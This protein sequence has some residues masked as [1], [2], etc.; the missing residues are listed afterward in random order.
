MKFLII[1]HVCHKMDRMYFGGYGPYV[2]EMNL[3]LK[4]VDNVRVIAP[5]KC[6]TFNP[7]DVAYEHANLGFVPVPSFDLTSFLSA[8]RAVIVMPIIV[9][10]MLLGMLWA[11]HIHLRCPGNM[12]LLG[13]FV[14]ILF[15]DK[16][17]TAKYAGNWDAS[18]RQPWSYR[19]QRY[20]LSNPLLTRN[21]QALVYGEWPG[22]TRNIRSSFTASY[23]EAEIEPLEARSLNGEIRLVFVGGLTPGKQPLLAV[24]ALQL[25][26]ERGVNASLELMGEGTERD[27]LEVYI[28][29]HRLGRYVRL[30]GNASAETVKSKLKAAHFL[31]FLSRSEGWPKAVAEAMFWGCVPITTCISCVPFMLGN[32]SRGALIEPT[33]EEAVSAIEWYLNNPDLY[34]KHAN[35]AAEWSRQFT[36]EKFE[37]EIVTL[38]RPTAEGCI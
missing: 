35:A 1:S 20:L 13:C 11:D 31:I 18:S 12:G 21:M 19:L 23:R 30:L 25:L 2:R 36:L 33:V 28:A 3:W 16:Q 10:R 27:R 38:L 37:G 34:T 26:I 24:Q 15:P 32:G 29:E 4:H 6:Q 22:Q 8:L 14:Q 9:Y 5:I 17:K 7:I